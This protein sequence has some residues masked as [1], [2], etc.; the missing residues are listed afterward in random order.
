L[1]HAVPKAWRVTIALTQ[2]LAVEP[3]RGG[4][5]GLPRSAFVLN[6]FF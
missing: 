3:L 2:P 6:R 4:C 5:E 1:L